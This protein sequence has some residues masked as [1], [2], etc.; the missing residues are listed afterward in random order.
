MLPHLWSKRCIINPQN[1]EYMKRLLLITALCAGLCSSCSN[2]DT[3]AAPEPVI[4]PVLPDTVV[5][6]VESSIALPELDA[7]TQK[8]IAQQGNVFAGNLML[9]MNKQVPDANLMISPMSLQYAL[10]MLSNG[11]SEAAL[12]EITDAMGMNDY[13]LDMLNSFFYNLTQTLTKEDKDFTLKLAN[14]IWIQE[15]FE[16]G[17]DF[18]KNN[19]AI[20]DADVSDIDFGQADKAKKTINAW[21]DKATNGTIKELSLKINTDTRA[22]LA[23][24]CYLKGK[25]TLP[26][27]K[28]ATKK[29]TFYNQDGTTSEVDMMHLTKE[30]NFRDSEGEPYMAV[31]LPYGNQTFHMLVILPR[32]DKTLEEIIPT[33]RWSNLGLGGEKVNVALPKFKIEAKY[34]EKIM[35]SVKDMGINQIFL[36]GSLPGINEELFV[37]QI[38]QDTFIEVDESGT[39]ASAVTT[40]GMELAS[41]GADYTPPTYTI[42][43]DRP[44]VFAIREKATGAVLFMG[45]VVQM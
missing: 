7:R 23:N 36:P 12:K 20:F 31:E 4:D 40:I 8:A 37:G 3:P 29:E 19:K 24:A 21:A 18:I 5:N 30:F 39:E 41:S 10:G 42:R 14:V 38:A 16:V 43:M 28:K 35:N 9:Q 32:E 6:K 45:K 13:S 34:P 33:I 15:N 26:F 25:W 1:N 2:S 11:C 44:F 22:V 27:D 17:E